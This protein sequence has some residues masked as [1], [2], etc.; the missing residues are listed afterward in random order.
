VQISLR[1]EPLGE[2]AEWMHEYERFWNKNLDDFE[3]YFRD[4]KA[5]KEK[6]R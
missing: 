3:R 6:K 2:V 5:K 1:A 4:K